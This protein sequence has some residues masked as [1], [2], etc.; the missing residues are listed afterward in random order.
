M[1]KKEM[2]RTW[3]GKNKNPR[4]NKLQE[5]SFLVSEETDRKERGYPWRGVTAIS[6]ESIKGDGK[7]AGEDG[8][9]GGGGGWFS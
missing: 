1:K 3:G 2:L 7:S 9:G 6:W 8:G 5:Y 4:R